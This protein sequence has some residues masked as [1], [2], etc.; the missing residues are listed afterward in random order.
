M[1][2]ANFASPKATNMDSKEKSE[3]VV[4]EPSELS[5]K[6]LMFR[7]I[8][9]RERLYELEEEQPGPICIPEEDGGDVK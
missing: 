3:P 8:K 2:S 9:M 6:A 4:E 5:P 1:R 7:Q